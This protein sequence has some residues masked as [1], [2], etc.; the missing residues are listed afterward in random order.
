MSAAG[1]AVVVGFLTLEAASPRTWTK[2][3]DLGMRRVWPAL[4]ALGGWCVVH[5]GNARWRARGLVFSAYA[6]ADRGDTAAAT[7][8]L[9][10][11]LEAARCASPEVCDW[12]AVNAAT[13]LAV[14]AGGYRRAL[15]AADGWA[16]DARARGA[17]ADPRGHTFATINRAEALH[18]LGE[19]E[20]ALRLLVEVEPAASAGSAYLRDGLLL[21]RAW[22]L[23]QGG[24]ADEAWRALAA[25]DGRALGP[26]YRAEYHFTRA[27]ALSA[28]GDHAAAR[29]EARAGARAARRAASRRNALEI[30]ARL[31][32]A[33]GD[34]A[35]AIELHERA[36][37]H[38]YRGQAAPGLV[39]LGAAYERA[40]KAE[41]AR[42]A[43]AQAVERDPESV[44]T[45]AARAALARLGGGPPFPG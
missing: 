10:Q 15:A 12:G 5:L 37:A 21:L 8:G 2:L 33:A 1:L 9:D 39:A 4:A 45:A 41:Q 13:D 7:H 42:G 3:A 24:R 18:N 30:E 36:R 11:L 34:D 17:K 19:D 38:R 40:G 26:R 44:R 14:N 28:R 43:Y 25:V 32:A 6:A 22:I 31:A 27:V 29:A 20:A 16:A 35:R 23:A